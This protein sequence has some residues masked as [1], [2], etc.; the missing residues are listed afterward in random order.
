MTE[1]RIDGKGRVWKSL[2]VEKLSL[3]FLFPLYLEE[4]KRQD[5]SFKVSRKRAKRP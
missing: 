3:G 4:E 5:V 2:E 1:G